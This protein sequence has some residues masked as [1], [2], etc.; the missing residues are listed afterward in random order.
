M[1]NPCKCKDGD[2]KPSSKH[3]KCSKCCDRKFCT[4]KSKAYAT[5]GDNVWFVSK[6]GS[7]ERGKGTEREP[8][9]SLDHLIKLANNNTVV[10]AVLGEGEYEIT[11]DVDYMNLEFYGTTKVCGKTGIRYNH[12]GVG[13]RQPGAGQPVDR[14]TGAGTYTALADGDYDLISKSGPVCNSD[15]DI[16]DFNS[17]Q[18]CCSSVCVLSSIG[19][20]LCCKVSTGIAV[21]KTKE[22]YNVVDRETETLNEQDEFE[23]LQLTTTINFK[24][25]VKKANLKLISCKGFFQGKFNRTEIETRYAKITQSAGFAQNSINNKLYHSRSILDIQFDCSNYTEIENCI[26][27]RAM[28]YNQSTLKVT[29]L[30]REA[31]VVLIKSKVISSHVVARR[32]QIYESMIL[33]SNIYLGNLNLYQSNGT[34]A[35]DIDID[36]KRLAE[37]VEGHSLTFEQSP[38]GIDNTTKLH[39]YNR[40][41]LASRLNLSNL[42]FA[43]GSQWNFST[44]PNT[45]A[46][47]LSSSSIRGGVVLSSYGNQGPDPR[48]FALT[49]KSIVEL[50]DISLDKLPDGPN[51]MFFRDA[52]NVFHQPKSLTSTLSVEPTQGETQASVSEFIRTL[53]E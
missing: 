49:R 50:T 35:G 13:Q 8:F 43:A 15:I 19:S 46:Y 9:Y 22:F 16:E 36:E 11:E 34:F 6:D 30:V 51:F 18:T 10:K 33:T 21:G 44:F 48:T 5:R 29:G 45:Y 3:E 2:K 24:V 32:S 42:L 52:K 38:F 41:G 40:A 12:P 28:E 53:D 47:E 4:V 31:D 27:A 23:T 26:V 17:T 25:N 39:T 37:R 20:N 1:N 14:A 7:D